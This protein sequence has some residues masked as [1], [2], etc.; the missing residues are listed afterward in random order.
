MKKILQLLVVILGRLVKPE[1]GV[2]AAVCDPNTD[3]AKHYCDLYAVQDCSFAEIIEDPQID[4]VVLAVPA[5][6]HAQLAIEAMSAGKNVFVEKPLAM[7]QNEACEMINVAKAHNVELMVGHLLQYHPVFI[8]LRELVE[9]GALGRLTY[10]Y[11]NRL[12]FGKVRT[13]EDFVW[14]FAPHD[15]SMILALSGDQVSS[16]SVEASSVLQIG[17]ADTATLHLDFYSGLKAHVFVS[18]LHPDKEQ[19][20]V[21]VGESAMAVFDDTQPWG[22]KL[23]FYEHD[24][25]V[26]MSKPSLDK[27]DVQF[28]EVPQSEPLKNECQH[29]VH[30]VNGYEEPLTGGDEGLRGQRAVSGGNFQKT[31]GRVSLG[32]L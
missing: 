15:I 32:E 12:S 21:V 29:F 22:R 16:V 27:S 25:D 20:L 19:K 1:L 14:S 7:N 17:I 13:E 18:W 5:S 9:S 28:I 31:L 6:L 30:V 4:G 23:A 2:L 26:S 11:S 3:L 8:A 24:V 10:I